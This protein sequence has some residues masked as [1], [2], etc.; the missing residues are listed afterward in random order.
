MALIFAKSSF[1][2]RISVAKLHAT[3]R[4]RPQQTI[5]T[6]HSLIVTERRICEADMGQVGKEVLKGPPPGLSSPTQLVT[7]SNLSATD[8]YEGSWLD[9]VPIPATPTTSGS[10]SESFLSTDSRGRQL[11]YDPADFMDTMSSPSCG[12]G[13][14]MRMLWTKWFGNGNV[15]R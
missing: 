13:T 6:R 2:D 12:L 15:D 11:E 1:L 8:G 4:C 14:K 5:S 10:K 9:T 3:D 7:R